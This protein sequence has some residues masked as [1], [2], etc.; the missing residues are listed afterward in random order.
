MTPSYR[1]FLC[2]NSCL[3]RKS[4]WDKTFGFSHPYIPYVSFLLLVPLP[5][6][7]T[8]KKKKQYYFL[9]VLLNSRLWMK[10]IFHPHKM[11]GDP[12]ELV[13]GGATVS[14]SAP[15][16]AKSPCRL[17]TG[18]QSYQLAHLCFLCITVEDSEIARTRRKKWSPYLSPHE[19]K[20]HELPNE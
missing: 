6:S 16:M 1:H 20:C 4:K 8:K 10:W 18:L 11:K 19:N 14:N 5:Q 9:W 2:R 13:L 17:K 3:L 7:R 15:A 12:A